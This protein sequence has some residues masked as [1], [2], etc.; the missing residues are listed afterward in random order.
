MPIYRLL[1]VGPFGP[2]ASRSST[3][4]CDNDDAALALAEKLRAP[5]KEV[6]VRRVQQRFETRDM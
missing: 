5:G 1:S 2:I 3:Y 6:Q 4:Y